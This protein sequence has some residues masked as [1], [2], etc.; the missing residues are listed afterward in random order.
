M[1]FQHCYGFR[2]SDQPKALLR[3]IF[4]SFKHKIL[5]LDS[6]FFVI[7]KKSRQSLGLDDILL[8]FCIMSSKSFFFRLHSTLWL[9]NFYLTN[10]L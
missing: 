7:S 10:Q 8:P 4:K 9:F 5:I 1:L 6:N 3:Q 2:I